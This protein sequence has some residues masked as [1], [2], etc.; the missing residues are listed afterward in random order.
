MAQNIPK[1]IREVQKVM[2]INKDAGQT[3]PVDRVAGHADMLDSSHQRKPNESSMVARHSA[4]TAAVPS[5][6]KAENA[7]EWLDKCLSWTVQ[8]VS[9]WV[10]NNRLEFL[11]DKLLSSPFYFSLIHFIQT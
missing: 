6:H 11:Q 9:N 4:T 7:A 3:G 5:A 1:I 2:N 10:R 8:D